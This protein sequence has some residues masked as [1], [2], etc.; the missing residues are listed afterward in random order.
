MTPLPPAPA[1]TLFTIIA[2]HRR[3]AEILREQDP[4]QNRYSQDID[5]LLSYI[6]TQRVCPHCNKTLPSLNP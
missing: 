3:T 4:L 6:G 2:A 1:E 5:A